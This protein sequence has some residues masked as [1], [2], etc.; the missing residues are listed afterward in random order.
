MCG[1]KA[2]MPGRF[3]ISPISAMAP[4][5]ATG[6]AHGGASQIIVFAGLLTETHMRA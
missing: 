2:K 1:P 5:A 4:E 6:P 3:K